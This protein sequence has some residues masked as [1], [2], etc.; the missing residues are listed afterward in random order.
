MGLSQFGGYVLRVDQRK[1]E[2]HF[3]VAQLFAKSNLNQKV[4][5]IT[6]LGN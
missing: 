6:T 5:M 1:S 2:R 3:G 4:K